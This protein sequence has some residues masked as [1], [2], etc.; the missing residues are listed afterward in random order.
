MIRSGIDNLFN[1]M[2]A[3]DSVVNLFCE[4][5]EEKNNANICYIALHN[6]HNK[7]TNAAM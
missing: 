5:V 1:Q 4:N 2:S 3:I 7:F 6:M